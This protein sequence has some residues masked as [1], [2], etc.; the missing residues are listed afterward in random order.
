MPEFRQDG[1]AEFLT[2]QKLAIRMQQADKDFKMAE[3]YERTRH[4]GSAYFYYQL[5]KRRYPGTKYA[6][7]AT[8][9]LGELKANAR[10]DDGKDPLDVARE[11]FE[12]VFGKA[13][14]SEAPPERGPQDSPPP[15]SLPDGPQR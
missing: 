13:A 8:A 11:R 2:R 1:K 3:Y 10:P 12:Q 4:P 15:V 14:P 5:V 7:L 6:E 9:K